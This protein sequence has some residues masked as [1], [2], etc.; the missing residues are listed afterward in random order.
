[1]TPKL[2]S[3]WLATDPLSHFDT[4]CKKSHVEIQIINTV[5]DQLPLLPTPSLLLP[6][7]PPPPLPLPQPQ[8]LITL[9]NDSN[10]RVAAT[11][12]AR[13]DKI[14]AANNVVHCYAVAVRTHFVNEFFNRE[15]LMCVGDA[16]V[17]VDYQ[18]RDDS[19]S[20]CARVQARGQHVDS[21][22]LGC[23]RIDVVC[24][25]QHINFKIAAAAHAFVNLSAKPKLR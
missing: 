5:E 1:M 6:P 23:T 17:L 9:D 12:T 11:S 8:S 2:K 24:T 14:S 4:V 7:L 15:L 19:P 13:L 16:R 21:A 25:K 20:R 3:T 18:L 10:L 22:M